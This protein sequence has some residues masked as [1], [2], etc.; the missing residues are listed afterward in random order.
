MYK[1]IPNVT[2]FFLM[3]AGAYRFNIKTFNINYFNRHYDKIFLTLKNDRYFIIIT[4]IIKT[5]FFFKYSTYFHIKKK[6]Y[7]FHTKN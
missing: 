5:N 2:H 7:F 6:I 4:F 3:F 1:K